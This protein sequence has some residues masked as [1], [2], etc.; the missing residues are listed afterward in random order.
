[1]NVMQVGAPSAASART[2]LPHPLKGGGLR[3]RGWMVRLAGD[4][5]SL[6]ACLSLERLQPHRPAR[7][8]V[9]EPTAVPFCD[10]LMAFDSLGALQGV[11]RLLPRHP[12][13][14]R[15]S[16]PGS[17]RPDVRSAYP[18]EFAPLLTALRY[19]SQHILEVGELTLASG[20]DPQSTC[21]ALWDGIEAHLALPADGG[22]RFGSFGYVL[23]SEYMAL[24][25]GIDPRKIIHSLVELHGLHPDLGSQSG[26]SSAP[27]G[28]RTWS[29]RTSQAGGSPSG[30]V[31]TGT[32]PSG[33][34]EVQPIPLPI[35][36][37]EALARGCS[38]IGPP[39]LLAEP[40]CLRFH[41]VASREML[42]G[43]D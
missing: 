17:P 28:N 13:D 30:T 42:G 18:H 21:A 3:T 12:A 22:D 43:S 23:G 15:H 10:F 37:Q 20:A 31:P 35:A 32:A 7:D 29:V 9:G 24:A 41:W 6:E 4:L 19:S 40:A 33:T 11:C 38:L 14:L 8:P 25:E 36:L 5:P 16:L 1:M 2:P 39:R 27:E 34:G 26:L